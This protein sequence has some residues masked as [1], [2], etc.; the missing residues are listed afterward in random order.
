[1]NNE[2]LQLISE[3]ELVVV[4]LHSRWGKVRL[5]MQYRHGGF[6][7]EWKKVNINIKLVNM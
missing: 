4:N 1:M 2:V 5:K 6:F 3:S 7:G